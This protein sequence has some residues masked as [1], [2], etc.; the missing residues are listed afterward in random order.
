MKL[1]YLFFSMLAFVPLYSSASCI[2][3]Q[4]VRYKTLGSYGGDTACYRT[5]SIPPYASQY[6]G[7]FLDQH[8]M[9]YYHVMPSSSYKTTIVEAESPSAYQAARLSENKITQSLEGGVLVFKSDTSK[10]PDIGT[11]FFK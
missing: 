8:S 5:S 11:S 9:T 4:G 1:A 10:N 2:E 3:S 6:G 7:I